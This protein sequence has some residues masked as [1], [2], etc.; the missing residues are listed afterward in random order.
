MKPYLDY[1]LYFVTDRNLMNADT[2][3]SSVLLAI[4][5]GCTIVQLREK[6]TPSREFYETA[7][8]VRD[9]CRDHS[10]PFIINDRLD[11][12]LA[13]NAD[14]VHVGQDD[15]PAD[16]VRPL[17]GPDK[18]LGVSASNVK[19]ALK[20]RA[21][22]AD[23]LGVGAM[24]AT[25]TKK[26]ARTVSIDELKAIKSAA[27]LPV[28]AIGGVGPGTANALAGTGIDGIAVVSA[29]AAAADVEAAARELKRLWLDL[30]KEKR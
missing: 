1:T 6:D 5:G 2:V 20:A 3:E 17:I 24:F 13:V 19:E 23:Y 10:V 14:G 22:G 9:V 27:A 21:D 18:I 4:R 25:D 30:M 29:V 26:D 7:L 15:L 16:V 11:I 12:A 8:R 28:V